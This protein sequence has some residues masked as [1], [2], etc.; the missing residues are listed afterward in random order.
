MPQSAEAA[1]V[2]SRKFIKECNGWSHDTN[3]TENGTLES[4]ILKTYLSHDMH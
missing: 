1:P 4:R 3:Q 2:T